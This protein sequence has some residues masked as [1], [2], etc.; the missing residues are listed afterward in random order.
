MFRRCDV[1]LHSSVDQN[2]FMIHSYGKHASQLSLIYAPRNLVQLRQTV[3]PDAGVRCRLIQIAGTG[4]DV[5]QLAAHVS[6]SVLP[7]VHPLLVTRVLLHQLSDGQFFLLQDHQRLL[8]LSLLLSEC[9]KS[10]Q[11]GS[12]RVYIYVHISIL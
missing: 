12:M 6:D 2:K 1:E 3:P 11:D 5:R 7:T 4:V 9:L 10:A 8:V